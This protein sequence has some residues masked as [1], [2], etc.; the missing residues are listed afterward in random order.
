[1]IENCDRHATRTSHDTG[2]VFLQL[3]NAHGNVSQ[4]TLHTIAPFLGLYFG[5]KVHS[6]AR[7]PH[8][9]SSEWQDASSFEHTPI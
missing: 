7:H 8:G 6:I 4:N 5:L 1:M 3:R 2:G 9:Q